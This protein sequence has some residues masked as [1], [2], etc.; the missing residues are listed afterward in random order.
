MYNY[1]SIAMPSLN[2]IAK[3]LSEIENEILL[4]LDKGL[5]FFFTVQEEVK[6]KK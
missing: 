6:K 4:I 5:H 3:M 2:A 1:T